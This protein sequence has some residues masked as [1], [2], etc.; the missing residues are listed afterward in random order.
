MADTVF[1]RSHIA[2]WEAALDE[3][4]PP[5][6]TEIEFAYLQQVDAFAATALNAGMTFRMRTRE[7]CDFA[8]ATVAA[9]SLAANIISRG[10][11]AGWLDARAEVICPA[12]PALDS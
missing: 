11:E 9:R 3:K 1:D 8:F 10:M 5:P 7:G 12:A 2:A 4:K 6:V